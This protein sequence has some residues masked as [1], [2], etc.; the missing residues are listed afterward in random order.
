[1]FI[2]LRKGK[3]RRS[4]NLVSRYYK[5]LLHRHGWVLSSFLATVCFSFL[6]LLCFDQIKGLFCLNTVFVINMKCSKSFFQSSSQHFHCFVEIGVM[7]VVM[8][9]DSLI[10]E[11]KCWKNV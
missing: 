4:H 2:F 6:C 7:S 1:M 10:V 8:T 3:K 5:Q 9:R 11:L